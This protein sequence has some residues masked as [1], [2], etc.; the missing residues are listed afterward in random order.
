M[1]A[2]TNS[3]ATVEEQDHWATFYLTAAGVSVE[4]SC[5]Y[6]FPTDPDTGDRRPVPLTP[7]RVAQNAIIDL[8]IELQRLHNWA[9]GAIRYQRL[10]D[11]IRSIR[12]AAE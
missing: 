4:C 7:D 11:E 5:G 6:A 9:H 1:T 8:A 3:D 2:R 12:G 10:I